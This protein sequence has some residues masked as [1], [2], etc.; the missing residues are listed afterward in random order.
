MIQAQ[1]QN[2]EHRTPEAKNNRQDTGVPVTAR[3][4]FNAIDSLK[5]T[6]HSSPLAD[7]LIFQFV[8]ESSQEGVWII[9]A[10]ARTYY[11]NRRLADMLGYTVEEMTG[12][13]IFFFMDEAAYKDAEYYLERRSSGIIE[14]HDFRFKTKT[15]DDCWVIVSTTPII[16]SDGHYQGAV[17]LLLDINERKQTEKALAEKEANARAIMESTL[18]TIILINKD[19]IVVDTNE[20]H[21]ARFGMN[22]KDILGKSMFSF[23]SQEIADRRYQSVKHVLETGQPLTGEDERN[24]RW[25]HYTINPVYVNGIISDKVA[26]FAEDI[27]ERKDMENRLRERERQLTTLIGN[28]PGFVYKCL[29]DRDWTMEYISDGIT[30]IAGYHPSELIANEKI[31]YNDLI[32]PD[33]REYVWS[34]LQKKIEKNERFQVEYP[35]LTKDGSVRWVWEQGRGI[36]SDEGV[37]LS[38]EGFI[39]DITEKKLA[40]EKLKESEVGL[41]ELN[42][43][44]DKL[45][46]I[47]AHDLRNPFHNLLSMS[48]LLAED[49]ESLSKDQIIRFG[50][51]MHAII[52]NQYQFMENLLTWARLQKNDFQY[53]PDFLNVQKQI[54]S[55]F[56][57][58]QPLAQAKSIALTST[59]PPGITVFAD[60]IML[61]IVLQN[62]ITNGI[63]FTQRG[64]CVAI[65][66]SSDGEEVKITILDTGIGMKP[67]QTEKLFDIISKISRR[68]TEDE[69][70]SGL[71]LILCKEFVEK[72]G[73]FITVE[74][75][76]GIGS[77]F[78]LNLPANPV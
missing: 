12:K 64:G 62:L 66:A 9:D 21:A 33:Y 16:D 23:L 73:G 68:G 58:L 1:N 27:T 13:D 26:V 60:A 50:S 41:R 47:I 24:G 3:F 69:K 10:S 42:A 49:I 22:R 25:T 78:I 31:T 54:V 39:T 61:Q 40:E 53:K 63:K 2:N 29:N 59:V 30:T 75:T 35:I 43:T 44:K 55:A 72:Q 57:L 76:P 74:S 38:L 19:G 14:Q 18:D 17:G 46:S 7:P 77:K 32:H 6:L 4:S 70:G 48:E 67:E 11:V 37:L 36:F 15:G 65:H 56:Q 8:V 5:S 34:E 51:E 20:G 71:G 45:F 28:L 52:K